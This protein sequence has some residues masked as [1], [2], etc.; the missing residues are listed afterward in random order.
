MK[1]EMNVDIFQMNVKSNGYRQLRNAILGAIVMLGFVIKSSAQSVEKDSILSSQ[2]V[3]IVTDY[4]PIVDDAFKLN[5]NPVSHDTLPTKS[6]LNYRILN[7]QHKTTIVLDS[8]KPAKMKN[9]TVDKLSNFLLKAGLGTY[10]TP[11]LDVYYNNLRSKQWQYAAHAH[12]LSS[13]YTSINQ[14]IANYSDNSV[15]AFVKYIGSGERIQLNT[16][17]NRN[18]NHIYSFNSRLYDADKYNNYYLNNIID[19]QGRAQSLNTDT[20]A[21]MHDVSLTY[22]NLNRAY[23][24]D[25][26]NKENAFDIKV[27]FSKMNDAQKLGATLQF[28]HTGI[29]DQTP[30]GVMTFVALSPVKFNVLAFTPYV[31]AGSTRWKAQLG[32]TIQQEFDTKKTSFFPNIWMNYYII[33]DYMTFHISANGYNKINSIRSISSDNPFLLTTNLVNQVNVNSNGNYKSTNTIADI[34]AAI[35]GNINTKFSYNLSGNYSYVKDML[36]YKEFQV[37][38]NLNTVLPN[39][40]VAFMPSANIHNYQF[41]TIY[42]N[43]RYWNLSGTLGYKLDQKLEATVQVTYQNFTMDTFKYAWYKEKVNGSLTVQYQHDEKLSFAV[44]LFYIGKRKGLSQQ[45]EFN[46]FT[47]VGNPYEVRNVEYDIKGYVDANISAEY[48]YNKKLSTFLSL[49]NLVNARIQR[50]Q[51]TPTMGFWLMGGVTYSF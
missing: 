19:V 26:V 16:S 5:D 29:T 14:G 38:T 50:W 39:T 11:L 4:K 36:F 42:D 34:T 8:I 35:K 2:Q 41:Q 6:V 25:I 20:T 30:P 37:F 43:V 51:H 45:A 27:D 24:S 40:I 17:Y 22:Y 23:N 18:V 3:N 49:N 13:N 32:A 9:E 33:P 48:K 15:D 21:L 47:S 31:K 10:A 12:H 1:Q 7:K 46:A 28:K 44:K